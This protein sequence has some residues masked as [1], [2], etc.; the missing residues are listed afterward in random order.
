MNKNQEQKEKRRA[1]IAPAIRLLPLQTEGNLLR[2]SFNGTHSGGQ[3]TDDGADQGGG[4]GSGGVGN[5][6][7][8]AKGWNLWDNDYDE[9]YED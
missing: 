1:Y 5:D 3:T 8:D 2:V 7:G 9:G 4:H 6:T